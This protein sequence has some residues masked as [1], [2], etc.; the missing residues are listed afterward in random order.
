MYKGKGLRQDQDTSNRENATPNESNKFYTR[1]RPANTKA[2]RNKDE[3]FRGRYIQRERDETYKTGGDGYKTCRVQWASCGGVGC[4][5][6]T[7]KECFPS[8]TIHTKVSTKSQRKTQP[9][10]DTCQ[11]NITPYESKLP[12]Q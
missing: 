2:L 6:S 7:A 12:R 1:L 3:Y 4:Q 5:A 10:N 9:S 8:R 11:D